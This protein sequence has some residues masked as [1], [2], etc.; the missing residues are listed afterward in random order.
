MNEDTVSYIKQVYQH[1]QDETPQVDIHGESEHM[2]CALLTDDTQEDDQNLYAAGYD[3]VMVEGVLDSGSCDHVMNPEDAPGYAVEESAGSRRKQEYSGAGGEK[4]PNQ[5]QMNLNMLADN[6]HTGETHKIN[7]TVQAA[8]VTKPLF[9]VGKICDN[10]MDVLF[11]AGYAITINPKTGK[12]VTRHPRHGGT[13][14]FHA[15]LQGPTKS[16]GTTQSASFRRQ[17]A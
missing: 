13:Y 9:S 15:K 12:E 8:K 4:I 16:S 1:L 10:G 17:G 2:D 3:F 11:R 14:Q 6:E 5:G 7:S